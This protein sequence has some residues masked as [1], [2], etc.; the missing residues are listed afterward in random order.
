MVLKLDQLLLALLFIFCNRYFILHIIFLFSDL[1]F[2]ESVVY[3]FD[4]RVLRVDE[5][6]LKVLFLLIVNFKHLLCQHLL[7][8]G[9]CRVIIRLGIAAHIFNLR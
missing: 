7:A 2:L 8:R 1:D 5:L 3:Y 6:L 9:Q 4:D